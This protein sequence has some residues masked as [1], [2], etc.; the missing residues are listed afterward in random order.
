MQLGKA[1]LNTA[2]CI[3]LFMCQ[4][5]GGEEKSL[6]TGTLEQWKKKNMCR[7]TRAE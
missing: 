1:I 2:V 5:L 3:Y 6:K 4:V 7:W